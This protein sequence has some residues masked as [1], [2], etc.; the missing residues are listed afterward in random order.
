M[1]VRSAFGRSKEEIMALCNMHVYTVY[2]IYINIY[3][4]DTDTKKSVCIYIYA[5][6]YIHCFVLNWHLDQL[7]NILSYSYRDSQKFM[8]YRHHFCHTRNF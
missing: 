4:Y 2:G 3:V 8:S 7:T 1:Q 6:V 5:Y